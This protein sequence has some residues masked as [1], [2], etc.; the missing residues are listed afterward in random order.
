MSRPKAEAAAAATQLHPI[1]VD[2]T[3]APNCQIFTDF[4]KKSR[5]LLLLF[6]CKTSHF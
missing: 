4:S 1:T 3:R 6:K 5:N 2:R